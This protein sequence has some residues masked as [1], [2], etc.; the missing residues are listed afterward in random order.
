MNGALGWVDVLGTLLV[1]LIVAAIPAWMSWKSR[2]E[3][4]EQHGLNAMLL[5]QLLDQSAWDS[6]HQSTLWDRSPV[7]LWETDAELN[8]TDWN[9]AYMHL[10]EFDSP[11][12][13]RSANAWLTRLTPESAAKW[14][15]IMQGLK[16]DPHPFDVEN[17]LLD[18]TE[19]RVI[20]SPVF[21]PGTRDLLGYRGTMHLEGDD[22]SM[23]ELVRRLDHITE[24]VQQT[25]ADLASHVDWEM[26]VKYESEHRDE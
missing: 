3:N 24:E 15:G 21:R 12:E 17:T 7:P 13:A 10:W 19:F 9:E 26:Q 1:A 25:R 8:I 14:P 5:R 11:E 2:T 20:G 18:G 23:R 16:A 22:V 4:R 6:A